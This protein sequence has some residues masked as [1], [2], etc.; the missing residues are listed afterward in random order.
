M[1]SY[2]LH[3]WRDAM[4]LAEFLKEQCAEI[5]LNLRQA[6]EL[7]ASLDRAAV[8]ELEKNNS[9]LVAE[10]IRRPESQRHAYFRKICMKSD[11]PTKV[12]SLVLFVLGAVRARD[13]LELRDQYRGSLA[14]GAGNRVTAA[15]A[16]AFAAGVDSLF[17]YDWPHEVFE[18]MGDYTDC[19]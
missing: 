1:G 5:N 17:V 18:A 15:G 7:Y 16:Y 3:A 12:A 10:M 13:L 6:R 2:E 14:P 9:E 19:D 8:I 11:V 4:A